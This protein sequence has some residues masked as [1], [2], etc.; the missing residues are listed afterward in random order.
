MNNIFNLLGIKVSPSDD[1][2][3]EDDKSTNP[4]DVA[5]SI[6]QYSDSSDENE[7]RRSQLLVEL[8]LILRIIAKDISDISKREYSLVMHDLLESLLCEHQTIHVSILSLLNNYLDIADSIKDDE[9]LYSSVQIRDFVCKK[10]ASITNVREYE[11]D[12]YLFKR[13]EDC[14]SAIKCI[15]SN[16]EEDFEKCLKEKEG[17]H[18]KKFT[19][20]S[21]TKARFSSNTDFKNI[22]ALCSKIHENLSSLLNMPFN[23]NVNMNMKEYN[24]QMFENDIA[25]FSDYFSSS[26]IELSHI[27]NFPV[28][29][30]CIVRLKKLDIRPCSMSDEIISRNLVLSSRIR[31][32]LL[33]QCKS[34]IDNGMFTSS[35]LSVG[36]FDGAIASDSV[37]YK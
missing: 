14:K 29:S 27:N 1:D 21:T 31:D 2:I 6:F 34:K 23:D 4:A 11:Y 35:I 12:L 37:V 18:L 36:M 15:L 10:L 8:L 9:K 33:K 24:K 30:Y 16:S 28:H 25:K 13:A 32:R 5:E 3:I 22:Y 26:P 7:K 19:P 20:I 17:I